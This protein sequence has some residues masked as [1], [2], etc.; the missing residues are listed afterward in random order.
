MTYDVSRKKN[1]MMRVTLMWTTNDFPDYGMLSGAIFSQA[2]SYFLVEF[3][4]GFKVNVI[5]CYFLVDIDFGYFWLTSE[6]YFFVDIS[7]GFSINIRQDYF[8]VDIG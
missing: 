3:S 6:R 8:L 4:Q 1:F 2:Q 7:Q 5:W